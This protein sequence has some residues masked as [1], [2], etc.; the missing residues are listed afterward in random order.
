M[1]TR[2]L[3]PP[4][5]SFE[6]RVRIGGH[7]AFPSR[8]RALIVEDDATI[9]ALLEEG[10]R[11]ERYVSDW[12][13]TGMSACRALTSSVHQLVLVN[14]GLP[15]VDVMHVVRE[16]RHQQPDAVIIVITARHEDIDV[17]AA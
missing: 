17:V 2:C 4:G 9:G 13:R 1:P 7:R 15:D 11:R 14:L 16:A 6:D 12:R 5:S 3:P 8:A 10:L